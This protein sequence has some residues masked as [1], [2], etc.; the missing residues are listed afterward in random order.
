[1]VCSECGCPIQRVQCELIHDQTGKRVTVCQACYALI[2][3]IA[4]NPYYIELQLDYY[5]ECERRW[6]IMHGK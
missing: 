6:Q 5:R 2:D 3:A 1:M 4:A